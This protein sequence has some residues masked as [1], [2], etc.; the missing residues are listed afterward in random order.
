MWFM[1][2]VRLLAMVTY[3]DVGVAY[4]FSAVGDPSNPDPTASCLHRPMKDDKDV[5]IAHRTLPCKSKVLILN[6]DNGRTTLAIVGDRGPYGK[7][8]KGRL[9]GRYKGA[10]D[11]SPA[12]N[13]KLKAKG[14]ANVLV[15]GI[16]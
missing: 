16:Q 3:F 14:E 8:K 12:L 4:T 9:K 6:L 7:H 1:E 5:L 10:V 15:L 2:L 11:L 13:R